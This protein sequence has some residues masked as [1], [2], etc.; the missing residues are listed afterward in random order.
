MAEQDDPALRPELTPAE[1][2]R[3]AFSEGATKARQH[4]Q[5]LMPRLPGLIILILLAIG[6]GWLG[7]RWAA[8]P[9]P[10]QQ[11]M[12]P[13]ED[14][15]RGPEQAASLG[16][17]ELPLRQDHSLSQERG[18]TVSSDIEE[19]GVER[20]PYLGIRGKTV[21]QGEVRGVKITAVFP[22]SPAA[23]AGLRSDLDP[24][25]GS[26]GG[27]SGGDAGHIIVGANRQPIRSEEDLGRLLAVSTPGSEVRFVV[28]SPDGTSY[29]VISV[30]LGTAPETSS[31]VATSAGQRAGNPGL[32]E[33]EI[34]R[35]ET[36]E[37][38][39]QVI[40]QAREERGFSLLRQDPRLQQVARRHSQDMAD[41]R[42]FAHFNPDGR[43]V[44]ERLQ[45]AN[46]TDFTTAG[47][48]IF[49]KKKVEDPAPIVVREWLSSP[50]HRKN[51]L[52]P[53]YTVGGVGIARG[54]RGELYVTQVF[55]ES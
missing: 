44:V 17:Q 28:A 3:S 6:A 18:D 35:R 27:E 23:Q 2:W 36:E 52:N 53:R 54:E 47:E 19:S 25:A 26:V 12:L 48:N 32:S 5:P 22:D 33:D 34:L 55:L 30:L 31:V 13:S 29:E 7:G 10:P 50:G 21:K 40:N 43:D 51:V 46:I 4:M 45:T 38:I 41:R 1:K 16:S 37:G 39:F 15:A 8:R 49:S 42:F 20:K 11:V 14:V 24:V 9:A